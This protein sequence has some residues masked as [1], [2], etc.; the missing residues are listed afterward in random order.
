MLLKRNL[1]DWLVIKINGMITCLLDLKCSNCLFFKKL[2]M[3]NT[4]V[5]TFNIILK[6][7][8]SS[9]EGLAVVD[10]LSNV[11]QCKSLM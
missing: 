8:V 5:I 1:F 6:R 7:D 3:V 9:T 10:R 2:Q 4:E 11:N